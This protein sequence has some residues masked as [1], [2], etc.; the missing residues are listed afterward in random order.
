MSSAKG[1]DWDVL[2][3]LECPVCVE[4]MASPTKMCEN[5][6]NVCDRCRS[7]V[8][9]CPTCKGKFTDVR[10]ISLENIAATAIYPCKNREAG[11]EEAFTV[12]DRTTH[13]SECL[14]QSRECPFRTLSEVNCSW[15]GTLSDIAAHVRNQHDSET[16]DTD[17]IFKVKLVDVLKAR[18]YRQAVF[19][20]GELFYMAWETGPLTFK[21]AVFHFG[22]KKETEVF[23]YGIKIGNH[24]EYIAVSRKCHSY[25]QDGFT[26]VLPWKCV[27]L[28]YNTIQ[29]YLSESADL[30]CEIEIG[31]QAL[32]GLIQEEMREVLPVFSDVHIQIY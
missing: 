21:F 28:H 19:I 14:F 32:N 15:T 9:A 31:R 5:G 10:N 23:K 26:H 20:L 4:Y 11:C 8:S 30:S 17:R 6:H 16:T 2:K 22:P 18:R 3:E 12:R 29:E 27:T 7:R 24:E 1:L 13:Q 25:V